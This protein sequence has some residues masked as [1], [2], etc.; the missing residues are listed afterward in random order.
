MANIL[1]IFKKFDYIENLFFT[2]ITKQ[3]NHTLYKILL[4]EEI[5]ENINLEISKINELII[6]KK[7]KYV[8][9][10]GD[11][12][13]IVNHF[14]I[15]KID[16]EKKIFFTFDDF[17]NHTTNLI[18]S[19]SCNIILSACPASVLKY[20]E[21]GYNSHYFDNTFF[22]QDNLN[23]ICKE[24]K[25]DVL[26]YG[27]KKADRKEYIDY[28]IKNNIK[29]K[30]VGTIVNN[31]ITEDELDNVISQSKIILDFSK[32]D[33][34]SKYEQNKFIKSIYH[35][36]GK[37]LRAGILN[38]LALIEYAPQLNLLFSGLNTFNN[39][40]EL[41]N[42]V[43]DLLQNSKKLDDE[44][45]KFHNICKNHIEK[46]SFEN[47]IKVIENSDRINPKIT[48]PPWYYNI[49]T[50]QFLR[51][52]SKKMNLIDFLKSMFFYDSLNSLKSSYLNIIY[53][54]KK[55][56]FLPYYILRNILKNYFST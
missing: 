41:L 1:I 56:I 45:K 35:I 43:K 8:F 6:K 2:K 7:I 22:H 21:Q 54:L 55:I 15:K 32:G 12:L 11:F 42:M 33:V 9:F 48:I 16:A 50:L 10:Q 39:K 36:K 44:T 51:N 5:S 4:E 30:L 27:E 47:L 3:S 18:S 13:T 52:F 40:E 19:N 53:F 49:C 37:F 46:Y 14:F 38:S 26:F 29:V 34:K 23:N 17:E 25:Y 20:K 28:L 31:Y 24:K